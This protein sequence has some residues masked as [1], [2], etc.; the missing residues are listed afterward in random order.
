MSNIDKN[1]AIA[2]YLKWL[3]VETKHDTL[4]NPHMPCT[5]DNWVHHSVALKFDSDWN[6]LMLAIEAIEDKKGVR[7][8]LNKRTFEV[9]YFGKRVVYSHDA[10]DKLTN[11]FTG[12]VQ[13]IELGLTK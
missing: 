6:W 12:V 5:P 11:A 2:K 1:E 8:F 9:Y 7:V 10:N 4:W 3:F 13:F